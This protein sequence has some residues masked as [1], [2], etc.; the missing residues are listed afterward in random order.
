MTEKCT[1]ILLVEDN[2]A[3]AALIREILEEPGAVTFEM[4]HV[5]RLNEGLS[6]LGAE[7]FD[8]VLLDLN[9]PDS[10]GIDTFLQTRAR[11]P[12][13][14]IVMMTS[15]ADESLGMQAVQEGA[16]D[17]LVKGQV[18]GDLLSKS[19]LYAIER[20][21]FMTLL[22]TLSIVDELTGLYNRRHMAALVEEEF[23]RASRYG[24]DLS[25]LMIDLDLFKEIN[26]TYGHVFGDL[27]LR[28]FG[29]SLKKQT[30]IS[31][32]CF[33][34]GGEEFMV[35][36]PQTDIA[37]ALTRAERIRE[38]C[39]KYQYTDGAKTAKVTVSIGAASINRHRPPQ[40][41]NLL[42][43]ADKALYRAKAE[44]RNRVNVYLD[45][46][47]DPF[48]SS[49]AQGD[50]DINHLKERLG[51][52]LDKTKRAAI[53]SMELLVR[54]MAD[55]RVQLHM[56]KVRQ[57]LGLL[58]TGLRLPPSIIDT[59]KR[60]ASLHDCFSVLLEKQL[61]EGEG[62]PDSMDHP[63]MLVELS[64]IFDF[65]SNERSVLLY[66]H[67]N[68]DGSGYP[69]GLEGNGIP[70][71]ARIFAIADA[72]ASS[73]C[74]DPARSFSKEQIE[75]ELAGQAGTRFDPLLVRL[76]LDI[77]KECRFPGDEEYKP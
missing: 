35:L 54:D 69:E 2:L 77:I 47:S 6:Q 53:A 8:A 1:R 31:D 76:A 21:R 42:A 24:S 56:S 22:R 11:A 43:Y 70:F 32:A 41:K 5:S 12:D 33:R 58:G 27:V 75:Q 7:P 25:C 64:E 52:I 51:S 59:L 10:D 62:A 44:G 71:G 39:E 29:A 23:C 66:H 67:E 36:L 74:R 16:Q 61:S 63:Y 30:R 68:Y 55:P 26:D 34:Y 15:H 13:V 17:Y 14:P 28:E 65:F 73:I 20:H 57:F 49:E 4:V 50:R 46:S 3:D 48:A 40:A 19:I 72:L 38:F 9:L 37:G 45:N 60:A 18:D